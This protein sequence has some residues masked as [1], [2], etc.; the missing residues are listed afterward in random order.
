MVRLVP[1]AQVQVKPFD[2]GGLVVLLGRGQRR[3]RSILLLLGALEEPA[4]WQ[5]LLGED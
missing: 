3:G 1:L 4:P 5:V 2:L